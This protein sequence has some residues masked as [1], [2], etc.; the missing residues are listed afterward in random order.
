MPFPK[1]YCKCLRRWLSQASFLALL[2]LT[3]CA[4]EPPRW[5]RP[6]GAPIATGQLQLD[7]TACRGEV[8]KA[9]TQGQATT[10]L[11][12]PF[13]LDREESRILNGCMADKGYMAQKGN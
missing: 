2:T 10:T 3:G 12:S 8:Q 5:Y 9:A 4:S 1:A 13:G 6:D 7:L 11:D